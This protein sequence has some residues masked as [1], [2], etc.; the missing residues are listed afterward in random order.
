MA[1]GGNECDPSI[2]YVDILLLQWNVR[3]HI[4]G[5]AVMTRTLTKISL[6]EGRIVHLWDV[7]GTRSCVWIGTWVFELVLIGCSWSK[8]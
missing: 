2:A 8:T 5:D 4:P 7:D 3:E 1:W 6:H